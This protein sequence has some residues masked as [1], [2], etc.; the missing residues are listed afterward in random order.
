MLNQ[1][2]RQKILY[3]L[4]TGPYNKHTHGRGLR[5]AKIAVGLGL[6][7]FAL[8]VYGLIDH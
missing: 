7:N 3:M 1:L 4:E 8:T 6:L 5:L 2:E